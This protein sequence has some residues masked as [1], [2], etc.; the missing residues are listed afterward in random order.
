MTRGEV[1]WTNLSPPGTS[2]AQAGPRPSIVIAD[3]G[4]LKTVLIIPFTSNKN[5]L[6]RPGTVLIKVDSQN[7]LLQDSVALIFHIQPCR[8]TKVSPLGKLS[9]PDMAAIQTELRR[10]FGL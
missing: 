10:V 1:V 7:R 2:G 8:R 3:N 9:T 4:S 6:A 5:A